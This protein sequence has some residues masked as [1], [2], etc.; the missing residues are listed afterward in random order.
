[1]IAVD[2]KRGCADERKIIP[3]VL[4]R[5]KGEIALAEGS[6]TGKSVSH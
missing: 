5:T 6:L 4:A 2:E 1:M 3:F